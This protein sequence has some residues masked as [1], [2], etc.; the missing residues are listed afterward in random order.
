MYCIVIITFIQFCNSA[1]ATYKDSLDKA[2]KT[3]KF[4]RNSTIQYNLS[5]KIVFIIQ[6]LN[7]YLGSFYPCIKNILIQI[8]VRNLKMYRWDR[9]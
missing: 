4:F 2:K 1:G 9:Q 7:N 3:L 8:I 6:C 5:A